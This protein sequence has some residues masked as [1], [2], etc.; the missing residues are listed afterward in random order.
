MIGK[1]NHVAIVVPD[2]AAASEVYGDT[3]GAYVSAP[4]DL[5]EHGVTTVFVE[6]PNTKIE[7]LHPL[8]PESRQEEPKSAKRR[9]NWRPFPSARLKCGDYRGP[10]RPWKSRWKAFQKGPGT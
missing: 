10:W 7:L 3:L 5:P 6:L 2:L 8:G 9:R 1:L 4:A